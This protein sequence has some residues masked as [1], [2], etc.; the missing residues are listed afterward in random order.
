MKSATLAIFV[1]LGASFAGMV[2]LLLYGIL[3]N[4]MPPG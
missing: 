3:H 4:G 1:C 2:G